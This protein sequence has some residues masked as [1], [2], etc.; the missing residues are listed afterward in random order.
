METFINQSSFIF[1]TISSK[2]FFLNFGNFLSD[3]GMFFT[4]DVFLIEEIALL[5]IWFS[6]SFF[7]TVFIF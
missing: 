1:E 5:N 4:E 6:L 7:E 2:V 3:F